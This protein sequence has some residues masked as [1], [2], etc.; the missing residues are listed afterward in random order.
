VRLADWLLFIQEQFCFVANRRLT[1]IFLHFRRRNNRFLMYGDGH[2]L[3][4]TQLHAGLFIIDLSLLL[5]PINWIL[6]YSRLVP[7]R[8]LLCATEMAHTILLC[9]ACFGGTKSLFSSQFS[10]T[11]TPSKDR[12]CFTFWST[13]RDSILQTSEPMDHFNCF[14][15]TWVSILIFQPAFF[16]WCLLSA[17]L[18][19]ALV[20]SKLGA[21]SITFG[22]TF[23]AMALDFMPPIGD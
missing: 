13:I 15:W 4:V 8:V 10:N 9:R 21:F 7:I 18:L 12:A 11:S 1:V 2:A 14:I 16:R 17:Q 6:S 5:V 23:L 22:V 3:F 20:H 19:L